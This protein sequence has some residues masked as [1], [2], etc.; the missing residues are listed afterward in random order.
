M[1]FRKKLIKEILRE[2]DKLLEDTNDTEVTAQADTVVSQTM[3]VTVN[4]IAVD[5]NSSGSIVKYLWDINADGWDDSTD[6]ASYTFSK[7]QGG[8]RDVIW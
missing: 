8:G 7:P 3:N 5:A 4:V 1:K 6:A 2:I